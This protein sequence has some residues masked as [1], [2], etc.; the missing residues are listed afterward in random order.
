HRFGAAPLPDVSGHVV[1]PVRAHSAVIPIDR[2][3]S[4]DAGL[5]DVTFG[6]SWLVTPRVPVASRP[7]RSFLP[8]DCRR[9]AF[10]SPHGIFESLPMGHMHNR[11]VEHF[12]RALTMGPIEW[13]TMTRRDQEP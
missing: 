12:M 3:G 6:R 1:N 5:P 11:M 9:Q 10:L 2:S 8:L 13:A 4:A 7:P